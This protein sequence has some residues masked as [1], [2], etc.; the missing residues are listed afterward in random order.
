MNITN[1]R[2]SGAAVSALNE[3]ADEITVILKTDQGLTDDERLELNEALDEGRS[4]ARSHR[5]CDEL[6]ST[7]SARTGRCGSCR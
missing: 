3:L 4:L 6:G 5:D 1:L 7:P 2:A